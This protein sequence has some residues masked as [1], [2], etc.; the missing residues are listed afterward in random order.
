[1]SHHETGVRG[2]E[3]RMADRM[4]F[5]SDAVFAIV[6][7]LL[8]L[9]LRPPELDGDG[10]LLSALAALSGHFEAFAITFGL[11]ALWWLIHMRA[12]RRLAVFDW[13][14]AI[15]NLLFLFFICLMPFASA[16]YGEHFTSLTTLELYWSVNLGASISM[17]LLY[18]VMFRG[19]GRLIGGVSGREFAGRLVQALA[20][21]VAFSFG[22]W[23]AEAGYVWGSR[24]CWALIFPVTM[25]SR[26]VWSPPK[27]S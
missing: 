8:V 13:P 4:I 12:T 1:M 10:D 9:E 25:L 7:T 19:G 5:F 22:I 18:L 24:F 17:I 14:V 21:A 23:A 26:L 11:V 20:P 3:A 16:L 15:C 6:L 27:A 2:H